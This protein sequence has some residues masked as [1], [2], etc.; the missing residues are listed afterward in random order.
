MTDALAAKFKGQ[1]Y[2]AQHVATVVTWIGILGGLLLFLCAVAI[3]L[4]V[5]APDR[6]PLPE[7]ERLVV[8]YAVSSAL[9]VNDVRARIEQQH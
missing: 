8:D 2:G 9:L 4:A 6:Q 5:L 3:L 7:E 1:V